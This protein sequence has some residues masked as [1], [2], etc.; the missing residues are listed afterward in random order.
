MLSPFIFL[1]VVAAAKTL[2]IILFSRHFLT[3]PGPMYE[4]PTLCLSESFEGAYHRYSLLSCVMQLWSYRLIWASQLR[5]DD[6]SKA[7]FLKHLTPCSCVFNLFRLLLMTL[8]L[9]F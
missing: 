1:I 2:L 4:L 6:K 8:P 9:G 7:V 5:F 3:T